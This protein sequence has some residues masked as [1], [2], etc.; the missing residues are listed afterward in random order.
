MENEVMNYD[1]TME[2]VEATEM[3]TEGS[4]MGTG[5]AMLIGAGLT[6]ATGAVIKLG[7][8]AIVAY[9]TKKEQRKTAEVDDTE[10]SEEK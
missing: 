8:K 10:P 7:K 4:G 9:K 6:I 5:V 2:E 1:E 3:E